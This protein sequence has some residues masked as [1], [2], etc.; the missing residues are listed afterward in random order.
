M[1]ESPRYICN[2]SVSL[3]FYSK[4]RKSDVWTF[5][6]Y[7]KSPGLHIGDAGPAFAVWVP[8]GETTHKPTKVT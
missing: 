5:F 8:G 6:L 7:H 4:V 1:R 2:F 3:K